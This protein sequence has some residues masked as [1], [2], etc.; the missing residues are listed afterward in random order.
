NN[1]TSGKRDTSGCPI[2][3]RACAPAETASSARNNPMMNALI[4]IYLTRSPAEKFG[5]TGVITPRPSKSASTALKA[6][7]QDRH[8][9]K[10]APRCLLDSRYSSTYTWYRIYDDGQK[11]G[12]QST[13]SGRAVA[14]AR[15][16][17]APLR[18]RCRHARASSA[19]EH[20]AQLR[21]SLHGGR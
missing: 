7:A 15:A 12:L 19:R 9:P 8:E 16:T 17:H 18:D 10:F 5:P 4:A 13:G 1:C 3:T 20:Q 14:A 6:R 11:T 21:L 2:C